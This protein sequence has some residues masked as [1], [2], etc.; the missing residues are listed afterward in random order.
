MSLAELAEMELDEWQ[1]NVTEGITCIREEEYFNPLLGSWEPRWAAN[2]YGCVVARQNGKGAIIEARALAGLF[3][4][5][6][7]EIIYTSHHFRT[8]TD[9]FERMSYLVQNLIK[10][11]AD[12][13]KMYRNTM[14]GNGAQGIYLKNGQKMVFMARSKA[15]VRGM[16]PDVLILDEAMQKLGV[17]EVKAARLAVSARPNYQILNF[18]SAGDAEAVYFGAVRNSI[19]RVFDLGKK[20]DPMVPRAG[21]SEWSEEL[22]TAYC[23]DDCT[24]HSDPKD[25]Q[26]W[27]NT[28]PA[29]GY[30]LEFETIEDEYNTVGRMD[31]DAFSQERLSDPKNWPVEGGG[32]RVIPK[33]AWNNARRPDLATEGKFCLAVDTAPDDEWTCITACGVADDDSAY[34]E[35]T[36]DA[37]TGEY[38]YRP[39]SQWAVARIEKI[40]KSTKFP[41][42]VIDPATPAG[43]LVKQLEAKNIPIQLVTGRDYNQACGE[44]LTAIAPKKGNPATLVHTDQAPMESAAGNAARK[45]RV[46]LWSWDKLSDS[47]DITPITSGTKAHWGYRTHIYKKKVTPFFMWGD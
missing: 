11:D 13:R 36:I 21:W 28:N 23:D 44:F 27:L 42:V 22:H 35:I 31:I 33:D 2:E 5:G 45:N 10:N 3:L 17:Q 14:N 46:E 37:E 25:P 29:T 39:G 6:E 19:M 38:D 43:A 8:M 47:A 4:F 7:R 1:Y 34:V 32:W 18:G 20:S 9:M 16:S 24:A 15:S 12:A 30:R 41:F 26:T 40:H